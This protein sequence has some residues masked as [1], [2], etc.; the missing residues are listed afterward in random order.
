MKQSTD[1]VLM[2]RPARF[3]SNPDTAK[4]NSFQ[5]F[6]ETDL[7]LQA[8]S[9]FDKA[10]FLYRNA[11]VNVVVIQDTGIPQTPDAIFPNNRISFHQDGLV[12]IYPM[13]AENR[14]RE[15]ELVTLKR[16]EDEGIFSVNKK[17]DYS[18]FENKGLF[19]EG[20]GSM[21]LDRKNKQVYCAV[22]PRSDPHLV[23]K[24]AT[25]IGYQSIVF[26]ASLGTKQGS[27][28][29]YH[30]NV[31][32][33]IADDFV[34]I[35]AEAI[36]QKHQSRVMQ[37]L[38]DSGREIIVISQHQMLNFCGNILQLKTHN[39]DK[40]IA[41]SITAQGK[42]TSDQIK[43]IER[44]NTIVAAEIPNIERASG[45]SIRCMMAEIF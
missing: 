27:K 11:G 33:A 24:F 20:T 26:E 44:K 14:R 43:I 37:S 9:E 22:S 8:Q 34:V 6:E 1:T 45:G 35:T 32:L 19:L 10:V 17:I 13:K 39:G 15:R 4:D 5:I 18:N 36:N 31:M 23:E 30:T 21:I 3:Y 40:I 38:A 42:F 2:I 41:M 7:T 25:E 12:F 28:S 29:I 16:L